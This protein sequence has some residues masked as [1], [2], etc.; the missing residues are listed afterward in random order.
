MIPDSFAAPESFER[1]RAG[2]V[3]VG[4]QDSGARFAAR[5]ALDEAPFERPTVDSWRI[6]S[7]RAR[8]IAAEGLPIQYPRLDD[9]G[10]LW[11][12]PNA[13]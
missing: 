10:L 8:Q 2:L 1:I 6:A 7:A 4:H 5:T 9:R 13:T 12:D 11:V 3:T